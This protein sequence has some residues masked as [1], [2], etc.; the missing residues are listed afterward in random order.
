MPAPEII[1]QLVAKFSENCEAYRSGRY[2]EARLRQEFLDP[3]FAALGW[4][5]YNT[6]DVA[7]EYSDVVIEESLEVEGTAKAP[8]YAFKIGRVRKF[9]VEAKKPAV[10]IQYDIH[11][12]YQLRRE[13]E[14]TDRQIDALVYQL[15]GL[16]DEEIRIV[17]GV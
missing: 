5:V 16:T 3:F 8:D 12:A 4:D 7:P 13:I 17:E 2:N 9:F 1:H 15:Y 6:K 11:P 10:D 14:S